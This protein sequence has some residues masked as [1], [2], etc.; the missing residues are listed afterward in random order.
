M[1]CYS[2]ITGYR[3]IEKNP[4]GLRSIVFDIKK[5]FRD[6]PVTLPCGRCIGCRLEHSRQMAIRCYHESSLTD[7][8]CFLTLTFDDD[9]IPVNGSVDVRDFCL[10]MKKLRKISGPGVRY[11]HCG[12]YGPK[13]LRP[14]YHA[15]IFNFD[16]H[17]KYLWEEKD[18]TKLYRSETLEKLWPYGN[19]TIGAVTF[20][21]A[22]YVARYVTKKLKGKAAFEYDALG[23]KPEYATGSR[24]PGLGKPWFEK[25]KTE[26]FPF[27]EVI[28]RGMAV[29][30][31][32][33]YMRLLEQSDP[34]I[35][36]EVKAKR[37]NEGW[38]RAEDN[39]VDRLFVKEKIKLQNF[40]NLI[41]RYENENV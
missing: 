24:R 9:H 37:R 36:K 38:N 8:N 2:P 18:G 13:F 29:K 1:P 31:P 32:A 39:T 26:V 14:H 5:G 15:C 30:P 19:S 25:Y 17:D 41:R 16:F 40:K 3:A 33:Y 23:I 11:L 35:A 10:F 12:E 22:A 20:E 7:N 28:I 4:S 27:D 6:R 21:S 34:D